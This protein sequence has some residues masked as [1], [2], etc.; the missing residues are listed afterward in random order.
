[1]ERSLAGGGVEPARGKERD[2]VLGGRVNASAMRV[3]QYPPAENQSFQA[4]SG[5]DG[6]AGYQKK[7]RRGTRRQIPGVLLLETGSG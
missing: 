7:A 1:M 2:V 6:K 5:R 3:I 4:V